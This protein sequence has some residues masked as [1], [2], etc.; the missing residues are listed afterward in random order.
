[1]LA[2]W[3]CSLEDGGNET[4]ETN[5][6]EV[7][8]CVPGLVVYPPCPSC[9][10]VKLLGGEVVWNLVKLGTPPTK[11]QHTVGRVKFGQNRNGS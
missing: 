5:G 4:Q 1:M 11:Y 2:P 3:L 8:G 9:S 10:V 6:T 7:G